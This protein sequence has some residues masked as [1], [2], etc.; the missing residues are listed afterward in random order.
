M[1]PE[2][3]QPL[4]DEIEPIIAKEGWTKAGMGKMHK[5][6]S[7]LKE[8]QRLSGINI[9]TCLPSSSPLYAF[10]LPLPA[11]THVY[12]RFDAYSGHGPSRDAGYHAR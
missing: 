11:T 3:F 7:L 8:S 2:Y 10:F 9:C 4:R 5:L 6:D 12:V 1:S